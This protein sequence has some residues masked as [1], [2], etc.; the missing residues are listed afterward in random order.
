MFSPRRP[1]RGDVIVGVV[2]LVVVEVAIVYI[3]EDHP[4][5]Y[6]LDRPEVVFDL[7]VRWTQLSERLYLEFGE[8]DVR[9]FAKIKSYLER[10]GTL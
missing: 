8:F 7:A 4:V 10:N 3:V 2:D 5:S 9:D 6:W 1:L